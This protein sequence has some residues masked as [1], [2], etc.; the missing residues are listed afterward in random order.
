MESENKR[1]VNRLLL[2]LVLGASSMY[3]TNGLADISDGFDRP[4]T[5][6]GL[7]Q[8]LNGE[9]WTIA[10]GK[11]RIESGDAITYTQQIIDTFQ[12]GATRTHEIAAGVNDL[13]AVVPAAAD[14]FSQV[15]L[16]EVGQWSGLVFRYKDTLNYW[17]LAADVRGGRWVV[18]RYHNGKQG[19]FAM[20][21]VAPRN[22]DVIRVEFEG[23]MINVLINDTLWRTI[24][25]DTLRDGMGAG[26]LSYAGSRGN[27]ENGMAARFDHFVAAEGTCGN[28]IVDSQEFCDPGEN[29]SSVE[30]C[31]S[32]CGNYTRNATEWPFSSDSPFNTPIGSG[33]NYVE[34]DHIDLGT[35][36]A[37][38]SVYWSRSMVKGSETDPLVNVHYSTS[39]NI[40]HND[41][42][43]AATA[44]LHIPAGITGSG[45]IT[46]P[47]GDC[48]SN[49]DGQL[50]VVEPDGHSVHEFFKFKRISDTLAF[51][52]SHFWPNA[53]NDLVS[54]N[55]VSP[56]ARFAVGSQAWGGSG[57]AGVLRAKE[58]NGEGYKRIRHAL[59]IALGFTQLKESENRDD[60]Y[61]W[62]A[63][64]SDN[65]YRYYTGTIHM[66]ELLALPKK[67]EINIHELGL[68]D[69]GV[70]LAWALQ[71]YGGYVT[72]A[73][74]GK[75]WSGFFAIYA[76]ADAHG[77]KL[78]NMKN[79]L[80]IIVPLLT[81][82][83]NN[84]KNNIGG[85]GAYDSELWPPPDPVAN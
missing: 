72:D 43:Q 46:G 1:H 14:G 57:I 37:I 27:D 55:G 68:S 28:G 34:D 25:E 61:K 49:R 74:G 71:N 70:A 67:E 54:G 62:P 79:D 51:S 17:K 65:V 29:S 66:G 42:S 53:H 80:K 20:I 82:V 8:T 69:D 18:S 48:L 41:I 19:G 9:P 26:L 16:T 2:T 11:W 76:D 30:Q 75:D 47:D 5:D 39:F 4:D 12:D 58:V 63:A 24:Y 81:K 44:Q 73:G 7:G 64:N 77:E 83:S 50:L 23:E 36:R 13:I 10:K 78:I 52:H 33:A 31:N 59:S 38:N 45:P 60:T 85:G 35:A 40:C 84:D 6:D 56:Q 22:G 21:P 3:A 15:T 32:T